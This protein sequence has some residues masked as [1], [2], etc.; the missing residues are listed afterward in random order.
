MNLRQENAYA[1]F[2]NDMIAG[3]LISLCIS[4]FKARKMK[5]GGIRAP[6]AKEE[7]VLQCVERR[8][9]KAEVF[10]CYQDVFG[11]DEYPHHS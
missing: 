11:E 3:D 7:K 5:N 10:A 6:R 8:L 2:L 4:Q 1:A 9:G